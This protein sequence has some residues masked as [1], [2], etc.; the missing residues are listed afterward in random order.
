MGT[1]Q[2]SAD[3]LARSRFVV[4][5]RIETVAALNDLVRPSDAAG[6]AFAAAH[7]ESFDAMLDDHPCGGRCSTTAGGRGG[8]RTGSACRPPAGSQLRG[9]DRRRARPWATG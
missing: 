8:S 5:P 6:R 4:S 7:R 2:I 1:W 9:G 3:L